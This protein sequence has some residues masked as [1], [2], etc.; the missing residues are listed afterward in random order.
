MTKHRWLWLMPALLL[1]LAVLGLGWWG[2][3]QLT[4]APPL[5]STTIAE[6]AASNVTKAPTVTKPVN[7]S[8]ADTATFVQAKSQSGEL[9]KRYGI[10]SLVIPDVDI[11]LPVFNVMTDATLSVGVGR[12]FPNRTMGEGNNVY[13]AHNFAG[14]DVLLNRIDRLKNGQRLYL[15]D[16]QRTY[17][18]A[19]VYNRVVEMHEVALL[20][21]TKESR[22]TLIRCEGPYQTKYRRVVVGRLVSSTNGVTAK[23]QAAI[24]QAS[25]VKAPAPVGKVHR[26]FLATIAAAAMNGKLTWP[27]WLLVGLWWLLLIGGIWGYRREQ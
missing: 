18:Y 7:L 8:E 12:Y 27:V 6:H 26:G 10:G 9:A 24:K 1:A 20:N 11:A 15:T 22:L 2:H 5:A 4:Q 16:Y 14:A 3:A 19:V 25:A 17:T 21:Q 23:P 13:A